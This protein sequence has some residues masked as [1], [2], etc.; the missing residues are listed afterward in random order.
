MCVQ[1]EL[2]VHLQS[3]MARGVGWVAGRTRRT[4]VMKL[5]AGS[6]SVVSVV[7][8]PLDERGQ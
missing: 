2:P 1:Y 6:P 5:V 8:L 3:V 4:L 7:F